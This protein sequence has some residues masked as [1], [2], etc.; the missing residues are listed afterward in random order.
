MAD[1]GGFVWNYILFR[2]EMRMA[3]IDYNGDE[4]YVVLPRSVGKTGYYTLTIDGKTTSG[5]FAV[6]NAVTSEVISEYEIPGNTVYVNGILVYPT[7]SG[8]AGSMITIN[9]QKNLSGTVETRTSDLL[10]HLTLPD[11][12]KKDVSYGS[13][14]AT[15]CTY[16]DSQGNEQM[17]VYMKGGWGTKDY[18][19]DQG[20]SGG[21]GEVYAASSEVTIVS[22]VAGKT[23]QLTYP[24]MSVGEILLILV[25]IIA[26]IY[27]LTSRKG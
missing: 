11:G 15:P 7:S 19:L 9:T 14:L 2:E 8:G 5:S 12:T 10:W 20:Y 17:A 1:I 4:D 25:G 27:L 6:G 22:N 24:K 18:A 13:N 21:P 23:V 3:R 16:I 26:L